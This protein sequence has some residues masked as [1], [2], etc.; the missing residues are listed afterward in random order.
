MAETNKK[1]GESQY[2]HAGTLGFI[3][4]A[5]QEY[6]EFT[7]PLPKDFEEKLRKLRRDAPS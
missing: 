6:M 2:L 5:T 4:P 3:H 7:S 1:K